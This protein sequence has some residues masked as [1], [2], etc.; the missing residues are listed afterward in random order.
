M[1]NSLL[2]TGDAC[3]FVF[4]NDSNKKI[5]NVTQCQDQVWVSKLKKLISTKLKIKST[6]K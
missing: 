2:F 6:T 3:F 5:Q 4:L 1:E